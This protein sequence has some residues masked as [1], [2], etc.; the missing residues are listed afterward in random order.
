MEQH[1]RCDC[2]QDNQLLR[3][4]RID[5]YRCIPE[6]YLIYVWRIEEISGSKTIRYGRAWTGITNL[7][8]I[9]VETIRISTKCIIIHTTSHSYTGFIAQDIIWL[10]WIM[11]VSY[12]S[13][14]V[15]VQ[16]I[17]TVLFIPMFTTKI[18]FRAVPK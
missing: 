5:I 14:N 7:H 2:N 12:L 6:N 13:L 8:F 11:S 16:V 17:Y 15:Y 1:Q 4:R 10:S 9:F 18:F 3:H